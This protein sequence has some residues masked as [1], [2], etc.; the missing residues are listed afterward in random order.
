MLIIGFYN[1]QYQDTFN[2]RS[3]LSA[4]ILCSDRSKYIQT[5]ITVYKNTSIPHNSLEDIDK[6]LLSN[7]YRRGVLF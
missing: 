1:W 6:V 5:N 3:F 4:Y 2:R 7:Q